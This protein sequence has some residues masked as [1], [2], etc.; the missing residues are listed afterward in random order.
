VPE[1]M[2]TVAVLA[3]GGLLV[4]VLA[5]LPPIEWLSGWAAVGTIALTFL[6]GYSNVAMGEVVGRVLAPN[7]VG[8]DAYSSTVSRI[9]DRYELVLPRTHPAAITLAHSRGLAD[10]VRGMSHEL[11]RLTPPAAAERFH[12]NLLAVFVET[13]RQLQ[14]SASGQAFDRT[15]L[16]ELLDQQAPVAAAANTVCR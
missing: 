1:M 3:G 14:H 9:G 11:R 6:M 7:C 12:E 10:D 15:T 5:N 8:W 2:T 13:E 4:W 16:N